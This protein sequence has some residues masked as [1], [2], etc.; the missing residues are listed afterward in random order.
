MLSMKMIKKTLSKLHNKL[1][2]GDFR[3]YPVFEKKYRWRFYNFLNDLLF[4]IE[5]NKFKLK[6][7]WSKHLLIGQLI[8]F[9][10]S[11]FLFGT[12]IGILI[13]Q[14]D[15]NKLNIKKDKALDVADHFYKVN[16]MNEDSLLTIKEE[17]DSL[18]AYFNSREW[19]EFVI[20]KESNIDIPKSLPDSIFFIMERERVKNKI[21]HSIYWRLI[22]K[23]SSFRMVENKS[24]GAYGYMQVMPST[25]FY[26]SDSVG[27][28]DMTKPE[29]NIIMGSYILKRNFEK[30][31]KRGFS[32]EKSWE[33]ALSSYNAGMSRVINAGY[34]IPNIPETKKYV[35]FIIKEFKKRRS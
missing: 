32:E 20:S 34:N 13:N 5:E 23:E 6:Y 8:I 15:I 9:L 28:C 19:K 29:N 21:P 14:S 25:F 4:P 18:V 24:S 3:N 16:K 30:F 17:K 33:L 31:K 27:V 1:L 2:M 26:F 35:S 22:Q 12:S 10:F 7:L 11:I